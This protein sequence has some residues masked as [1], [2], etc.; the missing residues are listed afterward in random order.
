MSK[1]THSVYIALFF[2][3]GI[4]STV[5]LYINGKDYY[6]KPQELR[7]ELDST[8]T[9][10]WRPSGID[11][12]PKYKNKV[13]YHS[14]AHIVL[15]PKGY[16]GHALGIAGTLMMVFGVSIYMIR[17]RVRAFFRWGLLKH[18]LEFHIFLCVVGPIFV[19]Y[20]T[21]FKFGGI[22]SI[23]FWSMTAVVLSGVAGRLIYTK[24]PRSIKGN[25]LDSMEIARLQREY[26]LKLRDEHHL[27]DEII[28]QVEGYG[29]EG[30]K[31][32][33][34]TWSSIITVMKDYFIIKKSLTLL[35]QSLKNSGVTDPGLVKQILAT[36]KEKIALDR[37]TRVLRSMHRLFR[38]WHIFHLPFAIAM[39]VIMLIHV[40]VTIYYGATWIF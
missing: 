32:E 24:I 26:S 18:W 40:G 39:F 19:L 20:H 36:A 38:Y 23:S 12:I 37:K 29:T 15:E 21:A 35:K 11:E 7:P 17:K 2:I 5:L 25:E 3:I 28:D 31:G 13:G 9:L 4:T 6:S 27:S 30:K 14:D 22:V 33:P 8:L 34:G 16:L 10:L 1:L